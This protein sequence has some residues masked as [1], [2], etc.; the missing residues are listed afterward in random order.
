MKML[1]AISVRVASSAAAC[2]GINGGTSHGESDEWS[3]KAATHP[4]YCHD[5]HAT[6]LHLLGI[7]HEKLTF[8][9]NGMC[10]AKS[11]K[12]LAVEGGHA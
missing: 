5:V 2:A 7:D 12:K 4:T 6:V 11:S 9:H 3:Y 8:R 1:L 10:M